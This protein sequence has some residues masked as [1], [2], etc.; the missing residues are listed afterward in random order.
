MQCPR[1]QHENAADAAFCDECGARLETVCSGC[2]ESNRS[3]AKFCRKCGH[4]LSAVVPVTPSRFD[5]PQA[6]TP[7]HLAEKILTS[8]LYR[9]TGKGEQAQE[10]FTTATTMYREMDMMG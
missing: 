9:R 5:T 2:G 6:Y 10:H 4:G 7:K 3:G 8:K 1:C